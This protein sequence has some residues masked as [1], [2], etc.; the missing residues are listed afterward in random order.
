MDA[1]GGA[2][3]ATVTLHGALLELGV[4]STLFVQRKRSN[5]ASVIGMPSTGFQALYQRFIPYLDNKSV[6]LL[7]HPW[8]LWS[9]G[10]A[11]GQKALNHPKVRE[12]D[13]ISLSWVSMFLGIDAI[14]RILRSGKPVVWT[15]YDTWAFTG[16]CHYSGAC[17]RYEQSCGHCPQLSRSSYWDL[18]NWVWG[19]KKKKWNT[20]RL[21]VVCPSRWLAGCA[22]NSSL[23]AGV[24]VETIPSGV[25]TSRYKPQ[26]KENARNLMG[27][28]MNRKL[29]LFIALKG[30]KNERKGGPV[31]DE[32][33]GIM[34]RK[35]PDQIPDLVILGGGQLHEG[36]AEKYRIH[37]RSFRDEASLA[38]LY[39][40]C[41]VLVAPSKADN[42]P[43]TVLEAMACG[44]PCVA[45]NIGGMPEVIEHRENGYLARPFDC[46]DLT[47]GIHAVLWDKD[48]HASFSAKAVQKIQSDFT[49]EQE[50]QRYL[51]LYGELLAD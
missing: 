10:L 30:L 38:A 34:Y 20:D 22:K 29:V 12:A 13:V 50:A 16:G 46:E 47:D 2:A 1:G 48:C 31:L 17:D 6:K 19:K 7:Y 18:S 37:T 39:S 49:A 28:P 41:D 45:F 25:D 32:A 35:Y 4:E 3:K 27:L 44:T 21:T 24:R 5:H 15:L 14:G 26:V 42:L 36:I 11:G 33:L 23:F 43:L 8:E 51:S 40:A 9:L